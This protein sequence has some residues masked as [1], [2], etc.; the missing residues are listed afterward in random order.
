MPGGRRCKSIIGCLLQPREMRTL[1]TD[2]R[3][4][5]AS[6]NF[7]RER[8]PAISFVQPLGCWKSRA[9]V[10]RQTSCWRARLFFGGSGSVWVQ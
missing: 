2:P 10:A 1:P 7:N 5:A 8:L 3:V 4:E 6:G 9:S